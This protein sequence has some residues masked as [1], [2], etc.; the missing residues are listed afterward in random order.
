ML[1]ASSEVLN[2]LVATVGAAILIAIGTSVVH[3]IR[4]RETSI[5]NSAEDNRTVSEFLFDTPADPRTH[6]PAREGWTTKVDRVLEGILKELLPD[7]NGGHNLRGQ[8]TRAELNAQQAATDAAK[9]VV[10]AETAATAAARAV[11]AAEAEAEA[12]TVERERVAE[13][14]KKADR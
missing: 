2:L 10:A 7:G 13:R 6:T 8:V 14:D 5:S 11:I 12:Q 1:A 4:K 9:A 3:I